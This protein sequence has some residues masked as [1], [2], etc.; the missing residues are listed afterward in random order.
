MVLSERI[1]ALR[2]LRAFRDSGDRELI[3]L[4]EVARPRFFPPGSLLCEKGKTGR[5]LILIVGGAAE[6]DG[7][8]LS[9]EHL[10]LASV[11]FGSP[12]PETVKA[13]ADGAQCLLLEQSYVFTLIAECPRVLLNSVGPESELRV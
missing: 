4:A 3:L 9:S 5:Y 2:R 12:I 8:Q 1:L 7:R 11:L 10:C 13:G 6:V